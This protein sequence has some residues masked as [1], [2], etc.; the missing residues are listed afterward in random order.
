[1]SE[2]LTGK[3]SYLETAYMVMVRVYMISDY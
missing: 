1:M 3:Y 2:W